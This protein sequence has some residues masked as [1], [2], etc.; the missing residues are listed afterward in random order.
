M[1]STE[2]QILPRSLLSTRNATNKGRDWELHIS[3]SC[4]WI[5]GRNGRDVVCLFSTINIS[6]SELLGLESYPLQRS[7]MLHGCNKEVV[8]LVESEFVDLSQLSRCIEELSL[9]CS[10]D[11]L[12]M[13]GTVSIENVSR[14]RVHIRYDVCYVLLLLLLLCL[15]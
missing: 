13:W 15:H 2:A 7:I 14:R 9:T 10:Y 12:I 1:L 4:H 6:P 5:N 11:T 3:V 8:L